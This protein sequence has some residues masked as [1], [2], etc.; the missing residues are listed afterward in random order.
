M[1]ILDENHRYWIL[2]MQINGKI[3]KISKKLETF[4]KTLEFLFL[5]VYNTIGNFSKTLFFVYNAK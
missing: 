5:L 4:P 3:K 1:S 2:V